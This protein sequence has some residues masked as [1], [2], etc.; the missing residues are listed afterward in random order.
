MKVSELRKRITEKSVTV[1]VNTEAGKEA[2][3]FPLLTVGDWAEVKR[4]TGVD[5]WDILLSA[6]SDNDPARLAKMSK[7]DIEELQRTMSVKLLRQISQA[8]QRYMVY[9]SLRRAD[10]ETSI[11]DVDFIITYGM[12]QNEYMKLIN[13]LLYGLSSDEASKE[14]FEEKKEVAKKDQEKKEESTIVT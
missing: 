4:E 1:T 12:G 14:A 5:M 9:C 13:F 8:A 11:E 10:A 6:G 3:K 2:I 7:E